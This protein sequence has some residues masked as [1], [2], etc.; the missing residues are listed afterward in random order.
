[1][2][3]LVAPLVLTTWLQPA[4]TVTAAIV[5]IIGVILTGAIQRKSAREAVKQAERSADA[6]ALSAA[7]SERS[8]EAAVDA[9]DVNRETAAGAARRA[10]A[11]ALAKRYQDAASLLGHEKAAVRLAGVYAMAR[12]ADDW[13]EHRQECIDVLCAYLRMPWLRLASGQDDP[14]DHEVR[15]AVLSV[16]EAHVDVRNGG[17]SWSPNE[18]DFTGA[19]FGDVYFNRPVFAGYLQ[20]LNAS[21]EG[22]FHIRELRIENETLARFMHCSIKGRLTIE[23]LE[24][25]D[26]FLDFGGTVIHEM[27]GLSLGV[28]HVA[29]SHLGLDDLELK[30]R[31]QVSIELIRSAQHDD[32]VSMHRVSL[33]NGSDIHLG[34]REA[35][36]SVESD[37]YA[38]L[39]MDKSLLDRLYVPDELSQAGAVI[40]LEWTDVWPPDQPKSKS[41][42]TN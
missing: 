10:E 32:V 38:T 1:V 42:Q 11:D 21:F 20:V 31:A 23:R 41:S 2:S 5:A 29:R 26:S 8:S 4:A 25:F 27:G 33:G 9:V 30:D 35:P 37:K 34:A 22:N 36:H 17:V 6:A 15:K 12:L 3:S 24:V 40:A 13:M 16:I 18:F 14:T 39:R 19:R 7:S 28:L